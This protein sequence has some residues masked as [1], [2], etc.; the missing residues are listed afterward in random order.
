MNT[1]NRNYR[2]T[3]SVFNPSGVGSHALVSSP[4]FTP[5]ATDIESLRDFRVSKRCLNADAIK[6]RHRMMRRARTRA[7]LGRWWMRQSCS[8]RSDEAD[9]GFPESPSLNVSEPSDVCPVS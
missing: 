1:D 6:L 8:R 5:G 3:E 2:S 4:G 9:S 7:K